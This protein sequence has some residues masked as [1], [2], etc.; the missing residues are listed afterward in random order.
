VPACGVPFF[1]LLGAGGVGGERQLLPRRA[2]LAGAVALVVLAVVGFAPPWLSARLAAQGDIAAAK[3]LDPLSVDPYLA[4]AA[5]AASPAQAIQ[6]LQAAVRKEPR[7]V[8]LRFNLGL[9]YARARRFRLARAELLEARRL[10]P[11]EARIVEAL[12][13]L[14]KRSIRSS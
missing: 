11:G 4:E 10:D 3:R 14:P 8:E 1:L 7:V 9:A 5:Q 13:S 6:P 2:A 12:K